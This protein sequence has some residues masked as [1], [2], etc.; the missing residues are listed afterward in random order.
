[1]AGRG[2]G[3]PVWA[4]WRRLCGSWGTPGTRGL[5]GSL[6]A[7]GPDSTLWVHNSAGGG[8]P[9]LGHP[10]SAALTL[11][12]SSGG[13]WRGARGAPWRG[14]LHLSERP[15]PLTTTTAHRRRHLLLTPPWP[16]ALVQRDAYIYQTLVFSVSRPRLSPTPAVASL[17]TGF[18]PN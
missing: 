15:L 3:E 10:P 11:P 7:S 13:L 16:S 14:G 2:A 17:G 6:S 9:S 1:M 5:G 18:S 8:D 12:S 4:A